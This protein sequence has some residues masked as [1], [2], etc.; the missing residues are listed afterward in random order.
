MLRIGYFENF[1]GHNSLL[2][3]GDSEGMMLLSELLG[4][5]SAQKREEVLLDKVPALEIQRGVS[6]TAKVTPKSLGMRRANSRSLPNSACFDWALSPDDWADVIERLHV[7]QKN[8]AGHQYPDD[9]LGV[10]EDVRVIVSM[11]EYDEP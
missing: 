6:I 2:F 10:V 3:A 7:L 1:K 11:N 4:E 5:L 8:G 9:F